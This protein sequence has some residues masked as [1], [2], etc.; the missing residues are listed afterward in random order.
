M[1]VF[2]V[3]LA[4][5]SGRLHWNWNWVYAMFEADEPAPSLIP[6]EKPEKPKRHKNKYQ[7]VCPSAWEIIKNIAYRLSTW[8]VPE[9]P[10]PCLMDCVAC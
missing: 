9:L 6:R 3:F 5:L 7:L 4:E 8:L 10:N 2:F 1:S